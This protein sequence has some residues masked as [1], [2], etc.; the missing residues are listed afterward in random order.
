MLR[1]T[2]V[3]CGYREGFTLR[4]IELEVEDGDLVG[5][6]GPNGSGKTTLLRT[7]CRELRPS[8]G[9]V[10]LEGE[11]LWAIPRRELARRV[12]VVAQFSNIVPMSVEEYVMLGRIPYYGRF[13]F[14]ESRRDREAA[15]RAMELAG[16]AEYRDHAMGT[17]SGGERQRVLIARALAQEPRLLLLDEPTSYLDLAHQVG[18]L[19]LIR[20]LNREMGLTVLMVLH[21][22]NAAIE[23]ARRLILMSGGA[24]HRLGAPEAIVDYKVL[25]EVYRTVLVVGRNAVSGK[26]FVFPV[27]EEMRA[28]RGRL[29][30]AREE[31]QG[32]AAG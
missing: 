24:I 13:Q 12:A 11:D 6:I 21:D 26:P 20:R 23:Y 16:C 31:G 5:I 10:E 25:E 19:D 7:A 3:Q 2:G 8:A 17:L 32:H 14:S 9:R 30:E 18:I 4:D 28:R 29:D 1:M 27:S 22:V 15:A